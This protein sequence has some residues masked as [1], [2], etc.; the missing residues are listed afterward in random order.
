M[1]ILQMKQTLSEVFFLP[2]T[3]TK[4]FLININ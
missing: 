4:L 3:D 2:Q 1:D